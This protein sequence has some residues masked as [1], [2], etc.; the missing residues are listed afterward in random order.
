QRIRGQLRVVGVLTRKD[1]GV[2]HSVSTMSAG[3]SSTGFRGN[4]RDKSTR[5]RVCT[6]WRKSR[7]RKL[8]GEEGRPT[9]LQAAALPCIAQPPKRLEVRHPGRI[10]AKPKRSCC[11]PIPG[12]QLHVLLHCLGGV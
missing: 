7:W 3:S 10:D 1:T 9:T 4:H 11:D 6:C 5:P 2:G 12:K 8:A